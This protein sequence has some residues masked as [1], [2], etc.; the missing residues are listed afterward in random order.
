M[1]VVLQKISDYGT[2]VPA[3][4]RGLPQASHI[5]NATNL[6]KAARDEVLAV[7]F[8]VQRHLVRCLTERKEVEKGVVDGRQLLAEK[9][10]GTPPAYSLPGVPDLQARCESF[11]HSARLAL[12][13][14]GRLVSVALREQ[15]GKDVPDTG[16][17]FDKL[18]SWCERELGADHP[19]THMVK[20]IEPWAAGVVQMRNAVD[21][22]KDGKGNALHV[23]NFR[24]GTERDSIVE[25]GWS[26]TGYA[27][28]PILEEMGY[29]EEGVLLVY[30][31]MLIGI[32]ECIK[33]MPQF[34]LGEI[35]E[36]ERDPACPIRLAVTLS[37][38]M[39]AHLHARDTSAKG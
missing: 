8:E 7:V 30:E 24:L 37:P 4:A 16:H 10:F 1:G 17:R 19:L 18:R 3:V 12:H 36:K 26:L 5:L 21:H 39:L 31:D 6:S 35:P 13:Q 11:L 9:G 25:P 20:E 38:E 29:I 22:P 33:G 34:R 32:F 27:P 14:C 15:L 23:L 2:E 28:R